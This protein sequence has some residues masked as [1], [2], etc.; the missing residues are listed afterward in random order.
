[1]LFALSD[2]AV[3]SRLV[4]ASLGKDHQLRGM[5]AVAASAS[6]A[7]NQCAGGTKSTTTRVVATWP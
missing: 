5:V 7:M 2:P 1:V 4:L 6:L 3:F